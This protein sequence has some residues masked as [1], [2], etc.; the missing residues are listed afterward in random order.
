[1]NAAHKI[2]KKVSGSAARE[3]SDFGLFVS[4]PST[5]TSGDRYVHPIPFNNTKFAPSKNKYF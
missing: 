4:E 3:A 5:W 2:Q 1:L